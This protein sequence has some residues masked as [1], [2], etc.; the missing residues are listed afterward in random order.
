MA[1]FLKLCTVHLLCYRDEPRLVG[2]NCMLYVDDS[3]LLV[4]CQ[5]GKLVT[6][7]LATMQVTSEVWA[8]LFILF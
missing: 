4:G 8:G 1:G 2:M 5:S 3:N 7:D 6:T